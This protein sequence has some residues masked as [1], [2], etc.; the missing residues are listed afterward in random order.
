MASTRYRLASLSSTQPPGSIWLALSLI[1]TGTVLNQWRRRYRFRRELKRL[2][3]SGPH[4]I[5]DIGLLR[6]HAEREMT[7][8]FWRA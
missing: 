6:N 2:F 3:K 7:K 4:L 8:P 1:G 5:E